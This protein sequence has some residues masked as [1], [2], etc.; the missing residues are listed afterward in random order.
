MEARIATMATFL[1]TPASAVSA[2]RCTLGSRLVLRGR[3]GLPG[4]EA[5]VLTRLPPAVSAI[6]LVVG[7]PASC[8]SAA[9]SRPVCP[10]SLEASYGGPSAFSWSAVMGPTV[11]IRCPAS[12]GV[13]ALRAVAC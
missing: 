2:A 10:T 7:V 13:M 11:P 8:R 12:C 5:S 4:K 9:Y 6:T 3:P 1:C